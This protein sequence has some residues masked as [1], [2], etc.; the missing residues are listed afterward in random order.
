MGWG[1]W[2][3]ILAASKF[4][5]ADLGRRR[6]HAN[7]KRKQQPGYL[8]LVLWS[9]TCRHLDNGPPQRYLAQQSTKYTSSR[10]AITFGSVSDCLSKSADS[11]LL[12]CFLGLRCG[13]CSSWFRIRQIQGSVSPFLLSASSFELRCR[14]MLKRWQP[15]R[16]T[17]LHQ[18]I[19]STW[20]RMSALSIKNSSQGKLL[21]HQQL[22]QLRGK[23]NLQE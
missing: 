6:L 1:K 9:Y 8:K 19:W 13:T 4:I 23:F 2:K 20:V 7:Q 3:K 14:Y 21:S 17:F 16:C 22:C 12:W 11:Q 18:Q 10:T 5:R 15:P